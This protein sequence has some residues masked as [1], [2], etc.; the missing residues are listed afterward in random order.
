MGSFWLSYL[1]MV[2]VLFLDYYHSIQES[3]LRK[4]PTFNETNDVMDVNI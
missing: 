1:E 4:V 2:E 3:K